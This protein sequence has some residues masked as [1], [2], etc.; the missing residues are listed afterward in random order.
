M[1]RTGAADVQALDGLVLATGA[2]TAAGFV[3]LETSPV[4]VSSP[5]ALRFL[6]G[7]VLQRAVLARVWDAS[8]G[9]IAP[10]AAA[11]PSSADVGEVNEDM[12]VVVVV[13]IVAGTPLEVD[14]DGE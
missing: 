11:E 2:L 14:A 5:V 8:T 9:E 13:L 1:T 4:L 6:S 7:A 12:V 10:V 3:F